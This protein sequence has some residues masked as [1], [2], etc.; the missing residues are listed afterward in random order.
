VTYYTHSRLPLADGTR[1]A[2]HRLFCAMPSRY[3][4]GDVVTIQGKNGKLIT[5][6]VRDRNDG[7]SDCDLSVP[8]AKVLMGPNYKK[9][10]RIKA[11]IVKVIKPKKK[12]NRKH[13]PYYCTADWIKNNT[14]RFW[15]IKN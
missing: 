2:E 12:L 10:G 7:K 4:L 3:E 15:S 14:T 13:S 1:Y 9:I 5:V 8:A 11:K 6:V